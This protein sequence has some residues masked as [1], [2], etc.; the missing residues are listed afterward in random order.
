ETLSAREVRQLLNR[1]KVD[2]IA[3]PGELLARHRSFLRIATLVDS[4]LGCVMLHRAPLSDRSATTEQVAERLHKIVVA[5]SSTENDA[6]VTLANDVLEPFL[7]EERELLERSTGKALCVAAEH[8]T[9]AAVYADEIGAYLFRDLPADKQQE[10]IRAFRVNVDVG[11]LH[12]TTLEK[13]RADLVAR[14][15]V[16]LGFIGWDPQASWMQRSG[17]WSRTLLQRTPDN[18]PPQHL[19]FELAVANSADWE[20]EFRRAFERLLFEMSSC[21]EEI[22]HLHESTADRQTIWW[23]ARY[24]GYTPA[25]R[26]L[27]M[28]SSEIDALTRALA[29]VRFDVGIDIVNYKRIAPE[30]RLQW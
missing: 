20:P 4:A 11:F 8:S 16:L 13:I 15:K 24:F 23:L 7:P 26:P 21:V 1:K 14:G 3:A 22:L 5:V 27:E 25:T 30:N 2:V 19:T 9:I 6:A 28:Q 10:A 29:E 17:T 18:Q 12:E